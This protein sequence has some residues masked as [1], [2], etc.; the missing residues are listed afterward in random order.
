MGFFPD[1]LTSKR[2]LFWSIVGRPYSKTVTEDWSLF[3]PHFWRGRIPPWDEM[4]WII[5]PSLL[6]L[7][8]LIPS[9]AATHPHPFQ[10]LDVNPFISTGSRFFFFF[11]LCLGNPGVQFFIRSAPWLGGYAAFDPK[12]QEKVF[13]LASY[14]QSG[15]ETYLQPAQTFPA[16][17]FFEFRASEL[18]CLT[19]TFFSRFTR[20]TLRPTLGNPS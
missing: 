20:L 19:S 10:V 11:P 6:P 3:S 7:Q 9:L 15:V 14:R 12:R 1:F 5:S 4:V 16:A 8:M 13:F 2:T 17:S 18:T